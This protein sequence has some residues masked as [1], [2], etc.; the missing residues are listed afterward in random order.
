MRRRLGDER[1]N[2][3]RGAPRLLKVAGPLIF[4]RPRR[5]TRRKGDFMA[6]DRKR[7]N[8]EAR[9]PKADKTAVSAPPAGLAA[10]AAAAPALSPKKKH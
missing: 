2:L 1:Q 9:K 3:Q 4:R 10:K 8:R 7:G 5:S 6:K